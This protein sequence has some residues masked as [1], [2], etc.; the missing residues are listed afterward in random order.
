MIMKRFLLLIFVFVFGVGLSAQEFFGG[1]IAG[2][3]MSQVGGDARGGYNKLGIVGGA[4]AGLDISEDLDVQMELKYIQKGSYSTDVENRPAF[5]PFLIKLD[6]IDLPI[7]F[8]YNLNKV[9]VNG[10]NL[11]WLKLEFGVSFDVLVNYRQ[12]IRG[13]VVLA[14]N[15]WNI[16]AFNTV[17]GARVSVKE[18]VEIGLRAVDSMTSIC[19]SSKYPY[20]N[21][22]VVYIRRLFGRYGMFNDVL[23]IAVFWR[24]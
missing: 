22:N 19:K 12:E 13:D 24:I 6:Y 21:G 4:F 18:N 23:Q 3:V 10:V 2:G 7:V 5:D 1:L 11:D 8:G 16:V 20:G 17:V 9:N 14:S 15:P